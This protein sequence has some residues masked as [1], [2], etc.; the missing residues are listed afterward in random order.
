KSGMTPEADLRNTALQRPST[1]PSFLPNVDDAL[2]AART[3]AGEPNKN[4]ALT[5]ITPHHGSEA[6]CATSATSLSVTTRDS[7]SRQGLDRLIDTLMA[8]PTPKP[9]M[10]V[11]K[12]YPAGFE[13]F[14]PLNPW[15]RAMPKPEKPPRPPL[16]Q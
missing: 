13:N 6:S 10:R 2:F 16:Y 12:G 4:G 8:K 3:I 14:V 1:T 5:T 9:M 11:G 15:G 7:A